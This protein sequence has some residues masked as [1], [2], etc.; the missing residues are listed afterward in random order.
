MFIVQNLDG[1]LKSFTKVTD[2]LESLIRRERVT[3]SVIRKM[4]SLN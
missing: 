4:R 1:I 2:Q 3:V